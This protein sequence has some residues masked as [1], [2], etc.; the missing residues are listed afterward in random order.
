[1]NE[2]VRKAL[3]IL[4]CLAE[5]PTPMG[6]TQ[7]A[8]QLQY[9][10]SSVFDILESLRAEEYIERVSESAPTYRIGVQSFRV[11]C[12]YGAH[13]DL[14]RFARP[15]LWNLSEQTGASAYLAKEQD[16]VLLYLEKA[17]GKASVRSACTIGSTNELYRTG[18]GKA[19][20]AAYA[21]ARV[22]ATAGSLTR[23][24]PRTIT[25][26]DA[27]EAE[28]VQI[29]RRGY[30]IDDGEDN[31]LLYC[32]AAPVFDYRNEPIGAISVSMVRGTVDA[33]EQAEAGRKIQRAALELSG[34]MGYAR[35]F[36]LEENRL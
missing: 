2:S 15:I 22:R 32:V 36:L 31:E 23:R 16:G 8:S 7:L 10:K 27:L 20:L 3:K 21:P 28:L 34:K 18:L 6:V 14:C 29:R 12:A 1:M 33:S 26:M 4:N 24:T 11:G 17:E 9:P 5:S 13:T 25:T 30:A 35:P 19:L